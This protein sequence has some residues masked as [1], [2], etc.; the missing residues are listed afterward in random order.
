M[1]KLKVIKQKEAVV[2]AESIRTNVEKNWSNPIM[3]VNP[4]PNQG[5]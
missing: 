4:I 1:F 3:D 5:Q 2:R